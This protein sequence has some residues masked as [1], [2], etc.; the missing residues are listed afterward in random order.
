[1]SLQPERLEDESEANHDDRKFVTFEGEGGNEYG[2]EVVDF[3][4][5]PDD[6][7]DRD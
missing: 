5:I 7:R 2:V 3:G 1:M 4:N 6:L